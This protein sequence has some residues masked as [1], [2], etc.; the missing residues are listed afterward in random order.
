MG[1]EQRLVRPHLRPNSALRVS[2]R[3]A[4]ACALALSVGKFVRWA[5]CKPFQLQ[6]A[7]SPRVVVPLKQTPMPLT[8][9]KAGCAS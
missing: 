8:A 9:Q 5:N 1:R 3:I 7:I 2:D 6:Q 4:R